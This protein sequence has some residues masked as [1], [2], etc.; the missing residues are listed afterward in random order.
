MQLNNGRDG[1]D[2]HRLPCFPHDLTVGTQANYNLGNS[3]AGNC[4]HLLFFLLLL[5]FIS[6]GNSST[7]GYFQ[8]TNLTVS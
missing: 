4:L 2:T 5:L 6:A 7:E 8:Q 1:C 3:I